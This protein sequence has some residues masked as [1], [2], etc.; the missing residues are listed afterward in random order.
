MSKLTVLNF[1]PIRKLE[2]EI[3]NYCLFI[4]PQASGKSTIAKLVYYFL[5]LK[6][7]VTRY[8]L[9]AVSTGSTI[10]NRD[11][12]ENTRRRFC[13]K[14]VQ[15]FGVSGDT[16]VRFC[17]DFQ[18]KEGYAIAIRS[19]EGSVRM[20]AP[21]SFYASLSDVFA[22][23]NDFIRTGTLQTDTV[24]QKANQQ[25]FYAE[26]RADIRSLFFDEGYTTIYVPACRSLL[27]SLSE[28]VHKI[29]D[30]L[31]VSSGD[32]MERISGL[33]KLFHRSLEEIIENK[34]QFSDVSV[35]VD[36]ES[37]GHIQTLIPK[38]LKGEYRYIHGEERLFYEGVQS[39]RLSLAS[40]GQQEAVWILQLI[41]SLV[42][43]NTKTT[44]LIEEP[45]AH[46]FPEAQKYMVW[47]ISLF[48]NLNGNRVI[49]TTHS[50]YILSTVNNLLYASRT[51]RRHPAETQ[52]IIPSAYWMEYD[53]TGAY[54]VDKGTIESLLEDDL[55]QIR[56][57]R[58]DEISVDLNREFDDLWLL[59]NDDD[60]AL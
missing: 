40:S 16:N 29:E 7:E 13:A 18:Y 1:G 17:I 2:L 46:L 50:P 15:V 9:E 53:K 20:E 35:I 23:A 41:F 4:G 14:F 49:I 45:E 28:E 58:I 54:Y 26:I 38:I 12:R 5:S 24:I 27:A 3:N 52:R 47:L 60:D 56:A 31:D 33:K 25:K 8:V 11:Y 6:D 55:K 10:D 43:N 48:A 32:F 59:Q 34:K 42:L 57:E 37:L 30:A 44:L 36:T 22:K 51:G 39:V 21:E 19:G